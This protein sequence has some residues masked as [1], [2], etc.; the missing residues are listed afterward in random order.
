MHL[1]KVNVKEGDKIREGQIIG[2]SGQTGY[3]EA[4]HLHISVKINSISIDP[5]VFM[6]FFNKNEKKVF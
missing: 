6:G 1:S 4:P 5:M 2:L 3:A